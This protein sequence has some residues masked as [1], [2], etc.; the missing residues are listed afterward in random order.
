MRNPYKDIEKL[1]EEYN[2]LYT[3]LN[4]FSTEASRQ[5][6]Q[7]LAQNKIVPAVPIQSRVKEWDSIQAKL[8]RKPR[9]I[10]KITELSDLIGLRAILLFQRDVQ[11]VCRIIE[12]HLSILE[13]ENTQERL[14]ESQF[15]YLSIHYIAEFPRQWYKLPTL[16][17][18]KNLKL[19]V[20]IQVRTTAQHIWATS[21][22]L[23]QY[24]QESQV[25]PSIRRTLHRISALLETVDL[26]LERVLEQRAS[27]QSAIDV[28][29]SKPLDVDSVAKVLDEVFPSKNKDTEE[30]YAS[31]LDDLIHLSVTTPD[32]LRE[33]LLKHRDAALRYDMESVEAIMDDEDLLAA[34][35]D[36]ADRINNGVFFTHVGLA[37]VAMS[38]EFGEEW[39]DYQSK[40]ASEEADL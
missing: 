27:H 33:I 15:G 11:V 26:E 7:L 24:K 39:D 6:T 28:T 31:L 16:T 12:T 29:S 37:Q 10:H 40:K 21:S 2:L 18:Y 35:A 38:Y 17:D 5:L 1:R 8:E 32:R 3:R 19:R 30:P 4:S 20:E 36:D 13:K 34:H 23:L 22:H 25:P 9:A 14:G